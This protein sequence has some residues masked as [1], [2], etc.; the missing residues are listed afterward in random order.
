MNVPMAVTTIA[1]PSGTHRSNAQ[2]S[3]G[4][5]TIPVSAPAPAATGRKVLIYEFG[6]VSYHSIESIEP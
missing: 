3:K 4:A 5:P 2:P 6:L 1:R